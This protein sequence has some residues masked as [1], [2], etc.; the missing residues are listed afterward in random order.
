MNYEIINLKNNYILRKMQI[1]DLDNYY[2]NNFNPL[3]EDISIFT[4]CKDSFS[5]EEIKNYFYNCLN[6]PNRVDFF[7]I[8]PANN[9]IGESVLNEID[10]K[11]KSANFRIAIFKKN[12]R[13]KKIGS[14]V[15]E[16]TIKYGFLNLN[17]DKITLD[18]FSFNKRA[19][20]SYEKAGFKIESIMK[21]DISLNGVFYDDISM[22]ITKDMWIYNNKNNI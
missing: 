7:I 13:N 18:V 21:N 3:D 6:N 20:K 8:N 10:Y 14:L 22:Y 12:E 11:N 16:E 17:L 4:G 15:I 9:I 1:D 19:K 5:Y 2:N